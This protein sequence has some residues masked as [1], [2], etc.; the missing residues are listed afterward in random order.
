M[1]IKSKTVIF[2]DLIILKIQVQTLIHTVTQIQSVFFIFLVIFCWIAFHYIKLLQVHHHLL[3]L[4]TSGKMNSSD[5]VYFP[6]TWY[7][8]TSTR[9]LLLR[10]ELQLFGVLNM[11]TKF[12][13]FSI[14][15]GCEQAWTKS[16]CNQEKLGRIGRASHH[17]YAS[18]WLSKQQ[19]FPV[20]QKKQ[21]AN[22]QGPI[23]WQWKEVQRS[24]CGPH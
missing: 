18:R 3:S 5:A 9:E 23:L 1:T 8:V 19:K 22:N 10:V 12:R 6:Q 21:E 13:E 17:N 11:W 24:A 4:Y 15:K 20:F 14:A 2:A 7:G 16:Q